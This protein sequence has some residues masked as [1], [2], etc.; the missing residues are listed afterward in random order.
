MQEE[1]LV[2][3]MFDKPG[4]KKYNRVCFHVAEGATIDI[5]DGEV[6]KKPVAKVQLRKAVCVLL[7]ARGAERKMGRAPA[8]ERRRPCEAET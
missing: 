3:E 7:R 6:G 2:S 5:Y 8:F 1:I 4:K